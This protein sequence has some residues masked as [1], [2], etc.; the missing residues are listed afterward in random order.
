MISLH[1]KEMC[2]IIN[3]STQKC[4]EQNWSLLIIMNFNNYTPGFKKF[5]SPECSGSWAVSRTSSL[6]IVC[7]DQ[8]FG[9]LLNFLF[10]FFSTFSS[11]HYHITWKKGC[12]SEMRPSWPWLGCLRKDLFSGGGRMEALR[13]RASGDQ[14][15][16]TCSPISSFFKAVQ[17]GLCSRD[18]Q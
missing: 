13:S 7:I 16:P 8:K 11:R 15:P 2:H 6:Y 9:F 12:R 1:S 14:A 5:W 17:L 3:A 10:F 4:V 18:I